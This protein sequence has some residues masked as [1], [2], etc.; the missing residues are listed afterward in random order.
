MAKNKNKNQQ[1]NAEF[2]NE[3][4]TAEANKKTSKNAKS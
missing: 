1:N 2:A 4:T 3:V